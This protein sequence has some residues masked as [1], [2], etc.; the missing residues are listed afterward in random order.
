MFFD[1][2]VIHH[3]KG[4]LLE[5]D[6]YYPF[7]LK[8]AGISDQALPV[9]PNNYLYNG[10]ELQQNEFSDG[11]GLEEY[12]YGF[13]GYDPQLGRFTEQDPLTDEF[14]TVSPYQYALNDPV[15]NID[16]DGLA[17]IP[18]AGVTI[19]AQTIHRMLAFSSFT[20]SI[21]GAVSQY[22]T[23]VSAISTVVHVAQIGG[24]VIDA[25]GVTESV[26]K[27]VM[28]PED[29][30]L[31]NKTTQ[32][33]WIN[34]SGERTGYTDLGRN[35]DFIFTSYIDKTYDGPQIW[36]V[37]GNKLTSI[38]NVTADE[39]ANGNLLSVSV[40]SSPPI[41]GETDNIPLFKG[42]NYFPGSGSK[43]NGKIDISNSKKFS[44]EYV[45]HASVPRFE[46]WGLSLLGYDIPDVAQKLDLRLSG[47]V[48]H[49][50][51]STDI[52]PS[53][54][55][56]VND[57]TLFHYEQPSFIGTF[58]E[59]PSFIDTSPSGVQMIPRAPKPT[60]YIRYSK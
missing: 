12:D 57:I 54:T 17:G 21:I 24:I 52:F 42:R 28:G 40:K 51:A 41:I 58:G 45:Q 22:G 31:N 46:A 25:V 19:T 20:S 14:A 55:L 18:L 5:E 7:G 44:S 38:I 36:N 49:I 37:E 15:A 60:F 47:N 23:A 13:R 50:A 43:Q 33:S 3:N 26:G 2:L 16:K 48:L 27:Q 10:K 56:K 34:G 59:D 11:T 39:D 53:A 30:Y 35:L 8:M 4:H 1:N 32:I 9:V 29:W 6:Q